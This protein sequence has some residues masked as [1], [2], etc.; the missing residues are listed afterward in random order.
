MEQLRKAVAEFFSSVRHKKGIS[1]EDAAAAVNYS[2]EKFLRFEAGEHDAGLS[3]LYKLISFYGAGVRD[4][5]MNFL[6]REETAFR[7]RHKR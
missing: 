1:V 4:D 3:D 2:T 7:K 5:F 6:M